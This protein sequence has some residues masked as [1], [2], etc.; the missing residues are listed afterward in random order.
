[1]SLLNNVLLT[2]QDTD[3][4]LYKITIVKYTKYL[5]GYSLILTCS[6]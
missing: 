6:V 1:M 4:E 3:Y 2:C 5:D